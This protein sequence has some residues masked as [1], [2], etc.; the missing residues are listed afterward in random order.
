MS[1]RLAL[2]LAAALAASAATADP[3]KLPLAVTNATERVAFCTFVYEG[4]ARTN[5]AIRPGMTWSEAFD[6]RRRLQLVCNRARQNAF[7]PLEAG[8]AYRLVAS[9]R[10]LDLAEASG[11]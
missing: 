4:K 11:E 1:L 7:G 6:P 2:S 8:K 9:G 3:R 5:L 10:K